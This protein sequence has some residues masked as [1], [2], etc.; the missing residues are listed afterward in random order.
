M[1][2]FLGYSIDLVA[3]T[4]NLSPKT[5]QPYVLKCL[6]TEEKTSQDQKNSFIIMH[7]H[8]EFAIMEVVRLSKEY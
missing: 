3:A 4:L 7:Q 2:E 8:V 5:I 1:K 6:N